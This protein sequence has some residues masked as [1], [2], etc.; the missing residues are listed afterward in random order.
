MQI[1]YSGLGGHGDVA[2]GIISGDRERRFDHALG[3]FGIEP[4][5]ADYA[6]R[7]E[8]L[9]VGHAHL[10]SVA[11]R[12]WRG[13]PA[14]LKWLHGTAPDAIILHT[15]T[16]LPPALLYARLAGI[17]LVAVEHQPNALKSRAEWAASRAV[18]RFADRVVML[19]E[20]SANE[21]RSRLGGAFRSDKAVIISNGIDTER[22]ARGERAFPPDG[23][24]V[25]GMAARFTPMKRQ[26]LTI[27]MIER[28]VAVRPEVDWRLRLAGA[29]EE[30]EHVTRVASQSAVAERITLT[31]ALNK[32]ELANFFRSLDIYVH[33]TE[34]ETLSVSLLEAMAAGLPIAASN[35]R[36]VDALLGSDPSLARLVEEQS[37]SA[38]A[39]AVLGFVN[40]PDHAQQMAQRARAA[41]RE[42]YSQERMFSGYAA[43]IAPLLGPRA[44]RRLSSPG[45]ASNQPVP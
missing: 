8:R 20:Q 18:F 36:G 9:V 4:L 35:V 25:V 2:F 23:P 26:D 19:T 5:L 33:I 41:C 45:K 3:F 14:M 38:F 16:A 29:G 40:W 10:P 39:D 13:W 21:I 1:L 43:L 27:A 34:G 17:P 15:T 22:Y 32:N 24:V 11:G 7:C 37:G 30:W 6:T 31:G 44:N 12:P 28:L 42:R